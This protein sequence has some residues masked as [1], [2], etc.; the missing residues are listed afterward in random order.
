MHPE[1]W[2]KYLWKT[3]H[4][5]ALGFPNDPDNNTKNTYK[6]FYLNF[7]RVIPCHKCA[8]NYKDHIIELNID[9]FLDSK[10]KLF[11]W[12]V[13]LHNI[14]N[15]DLGKKQLLLHDAYKIYMHD[16]DEK[17]LYKNNIWKYTTI[18]LVICLL[19]LIFFKKKL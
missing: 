7:W 12:T 3:I 4:Y 16:H 15:R 6:N 11:E 2:G 5:I 17:V 10:E 9:P 14:V 1:K 18:I 13:L 19:I 8:Q